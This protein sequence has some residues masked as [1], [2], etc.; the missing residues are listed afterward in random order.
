MTRTAD[1][2]LEQRLRAALRETAAAAPLRSPHSPP[3]ASG[4]RARRPRRVMQAA[5]IA[6]PAVLAATV[7]AFALDGSGPA[8]QPT[9]APMLVY[10][11]V[12]APAGRPLL[13]GLAA[14][15]VAS[16]PLR[17]PAGDY[18]YQ[19]TESWNLS[20]AVSGQ[21]V[22]TQVTPRLGEVWSTS[23]GPRRDIEREAATVAAGPLTAAEEAAARHAVSYG[24]ASDVPVTPGTPMTSTRGLPLQPAAL[25]QA[26][27]AVP[28]RHGPARLSSQIDVGYALQNLMIY[29]QY[30]PPSPALLS[31]VYRM[32]ATFPGVTDAGW[33]TDRAGRPGVA[34]AVPIGGAGY[35][36]SYRLIAD[37]RTGQL[38]DAEDIQIDPSGIRIRTPFVFSYLV[39]IRSAVTHGFIRPRAARP[40]PP[41]NLVTRS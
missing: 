15:A 36:H 17:A 26:L 22:S 16:P 39:F 24:P 33:V 10:Y 18:L 35:E 1:T 5:A 32:V 19:E 11:R 13:A 23:R 34:I 25:F 37:P 38:L 20:V 40:G 2:D 29:L 12:G 31:S 27:A 30:A 41:G 28:G 14:R 6:I 8:A 4:Q 21:A 3:A 9:A 7:T